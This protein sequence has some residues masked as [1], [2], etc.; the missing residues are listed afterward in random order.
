MWR[1]I[2]LCLFATAE[3]TVDHGTPNK[4][5]VRAHERPADFD[6]QAIL[7]SKRDAAQ[8]DSYSADESKKRLRV[9][10]TKLD[11]NKDGEVTVKD[12]EDWVYKSLMS[13]DE[14]ET[15][16][17]F[18]EV[19]QDHNGKVTW[20]EYVT[21]AFGTEDGKGLDPE[22]NK[23]MEEDRIYFDA[24][25]LDKD[26]A[27]SEQEF[28]TFQNPEHHPHMHTALIKNTLSEKD[29][30]KDGR[31]SEKEFLGEIYEQP[32]SEFYV[33]EK[34]R[35]KE[36]YDRNK[37]GYLDGEELVDWLIPNLHTVAREEAEHLFSSADKD[38]DGKLT[39]DE[40]VDDYST[41]V[42]SEATNFGEQL[43]EVAHEEL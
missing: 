10:A 9:I 17:R 20:K 36:E 12:L 8:F 11:Q 27:L 39:I 43:N 32:Q 18:E 14:E 35:F 3:E 41:F 15:R 2:L 23:L 6:H 7:G 34:S 38:N 4:H 5:V 19:D 22:Y 28:I 13:L 26:G 30:D 1:V 25:D 31:I 42:G 29:V 21:E 37:D 40:I 24:A 33:T 16:E